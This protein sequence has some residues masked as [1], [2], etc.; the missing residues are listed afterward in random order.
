MDITPAQ[1]YY[2]VKIYPEKISNEKAFPEYE[3]NVCYPAGQE[4]W[5]TAAKAINDI[6][7]SSSDEFY[8]IENPGD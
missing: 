1:L 8:Y 4:Y 5:K 3:K 6:H 7:K 2:I